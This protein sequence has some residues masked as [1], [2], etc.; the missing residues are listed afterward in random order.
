[1]T[2]VLFDLLPDVFARHARQRPEAPA[3]VEAQRTWSY[4]EV[5]RQAQA[6]SDR[7]LAQGVRPG[8]RVMLCLERSGAAVV[9]LLGILRAGAAYVPVDPSHPA[10]WHDRVRADCAPA[11]V[12]G[13]WHGTLQLGLP[14]LDITED[15]DAASP[16]GST[17]LPPPRL[18]PEDLMYVIYT[19]GST[20]EPKGVC[21]THGNV[22]R[23]FPAVS[24][25]MAFGLDDRWALSHS[26]AFGFSVWEVWG[27]WA[28][29][30]ALVVVPPALGL[31]PQRLRA[32]LD[33]TGVTVLSQTPTAFRQLA[34]ALDV[35]PS[36]WPHLRWVAF[37]G[38][39]LE[40]HVLAPW[41]ARHGDERPALANLYALTETSGEV[42]FHRVTRND[43]AAGAGSCLGT[44]LP[45]VQLLVV[46]A[47][48]KTLAVLDGSADRPEGQPEAQP[49]AQSAGEHPEAGPSIVGELV[50]A[51]PAVAAGY[52]QR[53]ELQ[54]ARFLRH[55]GRRAY[56]TGDRVRL[57]PEG[58]LWFE[59]RMDRQVK[60]R[61]HRL[62]LGAIEAVLA[63]HPDVRDAV[64]EVER[65]AA[66]AERLVAYVQR[67]DAMPRGPSEDEAVPP[68]AIAQD[69][70]WARHVG[71]RL[72]YYAVP[73]RWVAVRS[74]PMTVNGK[75]DWAALRRL[76]HP[77]LPSPAPATLSPVPPAPGPAFLPAPPELLAQV[78]RL[79]C[80]VLHLDDA[81]PEDD[82]FDRGGHSLPALELSLAVGEALGVQVSLTDL[83][84]TPTLGAYAALV[85]RRL[86]LGPQGLQTE[87]PGPADAVV[88]DDDPD[89]PPLR[90][91][92]ARARQAMAE[93]QPPYAACI[94]AA[95][96]T[97][98][99]VAHNTIWK[100]H[101][102]TAHAEVQA[103]R[104]A[105]RERGEASLAG[106]VMYSTAE[107]CSM[108]LSA[109]VWAGVSRFV[110]AIDMDD[111]RRF[112][113][114][115]PTVPCRTMLEW[116]RRP[117]AVRGGLLRH[118]MHALLEDWL[119]R[120]SV[121]P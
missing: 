9:A 74:W 50:V 31:A 15:S 54:A 63:A 59:G 109:S 20:G 4:A 10:A 94:V 32:W 56:R 44:P 87:S 34:R 110:Y 75:L 117:V 58:R 22:A 48:G 42:A 113:L 40:P 35:D 6:L 1:M 90:L 66:G 38:E 30:G 16:S 67:Q 107:P 121:R 116:L 84:E 120:Q 73:E 29:G 49:A 36:P 53:P 100:D 104:A 103:I 115:E 97:V 81:A 57:G 43:V 99:A 82:F 24:A 112:G 18:G 27:A 96:G 85:A 8:D 45:D 105:A 91:A 62:E 11:A 33:A 95:D 64:V 41:I 61:G 108:C 71:A 23:L 14:R 68:D 21:V 52:W 88:A 69:G 92:L 51:G 76:G 12:V 119:R 37:S 5:E 80:Q 3:V 47:S 25:H 98:L 26:L 77:P 83:F 46:D 118:E 70:V 78:T 28:H 17:G 55:E 86:S 72:P 79:W 65:T 7:L 101:D 19:S 60:V 111:E 102:P 2:A 89:G 93:G 39:P 13:T 106:S 114:A